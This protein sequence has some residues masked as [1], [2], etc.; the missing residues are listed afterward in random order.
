MQQTL[1]N[2]RFVQIFYFL[3]FLCKMRHFCTLR[4]STVSLYSYLGSL[5]DYEYKPLLT[6]DN[7]D[8]SPTCNTTPSAQEEHFNCQRCDSWEFVHDDEDINSSRNGRDTN[9]NTNGHI[10]N[11]PTTQRS[12][13]TNSAVNG[14]VIRRSRTSLMDSLDN[15]AVTFINGESK[16]GSRLTT[17]SFEDTKL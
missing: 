16:T 2:V 6:K 7:S 11:V 13:R 3:N 4:T 10:D 15:S 12:N 14:L 9:V 5:R 17:I 1:K 8:S